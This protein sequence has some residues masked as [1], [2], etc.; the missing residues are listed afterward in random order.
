MSQLKKISYEDN[1]LTSAL[2]NQG[3][4]SQSLEELAKET[5]YKIILNTQ[6]SSYPYVN[7]NGDV[8]EKNFSLTFKPNDPRIKAHEIIKALCLDAKDILIYDKY[9]EQR[10]IET[11]KFFK[12]LPMKNL[13]IIYFQTQLSQNR[14]SE[15]KSMCSQWKTIKD[16]KTFHLKNSH[17]RY[18]IIDNKI[19]IILS[20]GFNYLFDTSKDLT[21]LIRDIK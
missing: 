16:T 13:T 15:L 7:I 2:A 14:I 1:V 12:L 9:L 18:L 21:L 6:N 10:W 11:N 8:I 5:F 3:Y 19:Q 4:V 20:S 17:D